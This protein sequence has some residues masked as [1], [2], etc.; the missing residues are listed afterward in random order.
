M[1]RIPL[2]PGK[3]ALVANNCAY[4]GRWKWHTTALGYV[5]RD[6]RDKTQKAK[7]ILMHRQIMNPPAGLEVD[8]INHNGLDN[9]RCNLR[10][11]TRTQNAQNQLPRSGGSSQYKGVHRNKGNKKWTVS[12]GA[13]GQQYQLGS[14]HDEIYAALKYDEAARKYHGKFAC[15]NFTDEAN[16]LEAYDKVI[17]E[18][19]F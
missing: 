9:R 14:F 4:L 10:N 13:N 18:F 6:N 11:V 19:S 3:F 8:H 17:R 5:I 7:T 12:I 16:V 2:S 15:C 1:V